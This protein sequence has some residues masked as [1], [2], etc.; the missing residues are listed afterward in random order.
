MRRSFTTNVPLYSAQGLSRQTGRTSGARW[1]WK[2]PEGPYRLRRIR[3]IGNRR[4]F[5]RSAVSPDCHP[6][7]TS[8]PPVILHRHGIN[9]R[10]RSRTSCAGHWSRFTPITRLR[11]RIACRE[12]L[13]F[14]SRASRSHGVPWKIRETR[15]GT[16][17]GTVQRI[18]VLRQSHADYDSTG[19]HEKSPFGNRLTRRIL[20][21]L[22]IR[23][24]F[25]NGEPNR[26]MKAVSYRYRSVVCRISF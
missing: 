18:V 15:N 1:R 12:T 23:R 4:A 10:K 8:Q 9:R 3:G 25:R 7:R 20:L 6:P 19:Y 17:R 5:Q 11:W 21:T 2:R 22:C 13:F 14:V 26:S 16:R 24:V